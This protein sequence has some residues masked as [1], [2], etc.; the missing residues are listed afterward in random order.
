MPLVRD[1]PSHTRTL[2]LTAWKSDFAEKEVGVL[3]GTKLTM[4]QE[5]TLAAKVAA[6][7]R[8]SPAG[9][10]SHPLLSTGETYLVC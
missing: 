4:S 6:L 9:R 1:N 2:R 8:P 5:A 10:V 3:V 7:R